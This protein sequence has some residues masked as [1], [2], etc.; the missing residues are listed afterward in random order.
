MQKKLLN[1]AEY[2]NWLGAIKLSIKQSQVKAALAVNSQLIML[3]WNLGGQIVKKQQHAA[4]GTGF[5]DQLSKDLKA[6][7]PEMAGFSV[8]NIYEIVKFYKYF[9]QGIEIFNP[10]AGKIESE[11]KSR[12]KFQ[13]AI[14]KLEHT[15]IQQL[16]GEIEETPVLQLCLQVP[17]GAYC[18]DTAK[19]R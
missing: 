16:V 12:T 5:I 10:P 2:K 1:N 4:W 13:Q 9:S 15:K 6:E 11:K 17:W 14:G 7:F 3:Y 18:I 8:S 19:N